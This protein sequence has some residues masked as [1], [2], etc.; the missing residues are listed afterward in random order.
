MRAFRLY[1]L[2]W[3]A[4]HPSRVIGLLLLG[5]ALLPLLL[6]LLPIRKVPLTYNLRNL[7]V[8]WKTTLVTAIAFTLVTA[9][10]TVM[11]AFVNGMNRLTEQ[12]GHPGNVLVLSDG[13]TDE[14]FSNLPP[15]SVPLLPRDLQKMIPRA[16]D[17]QTYLASQEV[18][19]I[20]TY[21]I[22]NQAPG[23]KQR[24][25]VQMRG[26]DNIPISAQLH[27]I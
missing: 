19:V 14:A 24:R 5:L 25:F 23:R 18:Y 16:A 10:L 17:G 21:V 9:L 20:V 15:F 26:I 3:A 8:R 11:L 27:E 1:W 12:T 7:Q 2:H 4:E 22:P 13:A 6:A